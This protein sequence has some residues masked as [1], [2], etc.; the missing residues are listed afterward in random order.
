MTSQR[1]PIEYSMD[2]KPEDSPMVT[3]VQHMANNTT[4]KR[5]VPMAQADSVESVLLAMVEFDEAAL[6]LVFDPD[7]L[8]T[9]FRLILPS[10]LRDNWDKTEATMG[11]AAA[12]RTAATFHSCQGAWIATFISS[13]AAENLRHYIENQLSKPY[14]DTIQAYVSRCK[15]LRKQQFQ[16]QAVGRAVAPPLGDMMTRQVLIEGM[17]RGLPVDWRGEFLRYHRLH[18]YTIQEFQ[19]GMEHEKAEAD[20]KKKA[21]AAK[22][23]SN[24]TSKWK[25]NHRRKGQED[26]KE[27][28]YDYKNSRA[29]KSMASNIQE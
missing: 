20:R 21:N 13:M 11:I 22:K 27:A 2:F 29:A 9:N 3:V 26:R 19:D 15:T 25:N 4:L 23:T 6:A 7:D 16:L 8:Y 24:G 10:T 14:E 18:N 28:P 5:K 12:L 1:T 17:F